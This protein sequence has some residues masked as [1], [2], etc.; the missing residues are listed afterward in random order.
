MNSTFLDAATEA[1]SKL[2]SSKIAS[3]IEGGVAVS[4]FC[5]LSRFEA[6]I[7]AKIAATIWPA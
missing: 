6:A 3:S 7:P 1:V 2:Y 5:A 4:F